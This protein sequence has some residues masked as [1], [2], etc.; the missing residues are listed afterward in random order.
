MRDVR[1]RADHKDSLGF[2]SVVTRI[3]RIKG[4]A[5]ATRGPK[6]SAKGNRRVCLLA[7]RP[8]TRAMEERPRSDLRGGH[9]ILRLTMQYRHLSGDRGRCRG[10]KRGAHTIVGD[11]G[12]PL[13]EVAGLLEERQAH[14]P[15][16]REIERRHGVGLLRGDLNEGGCQLADHKPLFYLVEM[17]L[18]FM[19]RTQ[20]H[21]RKALRSRPALTTGDLLIPSSKISTRTK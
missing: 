19:H 21:Y 11:C 2:H 8:R 9:A 1:E 5:D 7:G 3:P 6:R 13:L 12:V 20:M 10:E 4:V 17:H 15:A 14:L 16:G 18:S